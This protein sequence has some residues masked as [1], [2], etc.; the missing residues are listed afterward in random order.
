MFTKRSQMTE[1]FEPLSIKG[2]LYGKNQPLGF[3]LGPCV[4][5]SYEQIQEVCGYLKEHLSV[6]FIFKASFD[7]AN[8][9]SVESFRGVGI[10]KG[11]TYLS[12]IKKEFDVAVTT[13][14]HLPSE[15]A[16]VAQVVDI[17]QIPAFLA[18][19]TDLILSAGKTLLPV[20]VKK[21]QFMAPRDMEHV[22]NKLLSTG[23]KKI[24]FTER[25]S[26]FGYN[27]LV[28][29]F[30]AFPIM[31]R[32]CA[33]TCY[34]VTHSAQLPG[35][36]KESG[37]EKAFMEPLALSAVASGCDCIFLETHKNPPQ[38]K[39]DKNTQ[40]ELEKVP[41]LVKKLAALRSFLQQNEPIN[42]W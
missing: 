26:C 19:Q 23:N 27:N 4:I 15:A 11:L 30:R 8:R 36:G 42:A 33:A 31:S 34:D 28:N 20:H 16:M 13:D 25:G 29:D 1:L 24:L 38:A 41:P 21:G 37:G 12:K 7:K 18:R 22:S 17:I 2:T 9:S 5:E 10:E 35:Q 3:I 14:I 6:P 39:S 40:M 32:Y